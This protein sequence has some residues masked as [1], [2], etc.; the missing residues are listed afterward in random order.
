[1]KKLL[2][3]LFSLAA[4]RYYEYLSIIITSIFVNKITD[5]KISICSSCDFDFD[6]IIHYGSFLFL[7][8]II[9]YFYSFL[10]KRKSMAQKLLE[11][12]Q[13]TNLND[14]YVNNL[15][16]DRVKVVFVWLLIL[17][18]LFVIIIF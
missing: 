17:A 9:Y 5:E 3:F 7:C 6:F 18:S 16:D 14:L 8:L 11:T 2:S 4:I 10:N 12:V 13:N 1:M 15:Y